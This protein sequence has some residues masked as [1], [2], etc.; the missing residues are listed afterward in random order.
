MPDD[1]VTYSAILVALVVGV[2]ALLAGEF[3]HGVEY[4]ITVGGVV[5]LAAVGGLTVAIARE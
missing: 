4:L 5:A 1:A 2:G 3:F